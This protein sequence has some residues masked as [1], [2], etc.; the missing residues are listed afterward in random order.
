MRGINIWL[1]ILLRETIELTHLQSNTIRIFTF[2]V[3]NRLTGTFLV[4]FIGEST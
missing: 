1:S 3:E 2:R 4:R